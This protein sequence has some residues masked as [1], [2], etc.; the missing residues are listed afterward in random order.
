MK[1]VA[2]RTFEVGIF[3][4]APKGEPQTVDEVIEPGCAPGPGRQNLDVEALGEDMARALNRIAMKAQCPNE[5][6]DPPDWLLDLLYR[7]LRQNAGKLSKRTREKEFA[8][9][10]DDEAARIEMIYVDL[11]CLDLL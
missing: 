6:T 9:L 5:G 8:A 1:A 11:Q 7:F 2:L 3:M 10:T 4:P